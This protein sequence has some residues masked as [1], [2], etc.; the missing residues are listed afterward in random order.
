MLFSFPG[1]WCCGGG[2]G[3]RGGRGSQ[4]TPGQGKVAAE[5][6]GELFGT[7]SAIT[8]APMARLAWLAISLLPGSDDGSR[9]SHHQSP[10]EFSCLPLFQK[11]QLP[12]HGRKVSV[13]AETL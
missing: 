13:M 12:A 3:L 11:K 6:P 9:Q 5:K 7:W 1:E 2:Q 4:G 10:R 8:T